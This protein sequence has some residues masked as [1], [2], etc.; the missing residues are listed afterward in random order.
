MVSEA[1]KL[2]S[3]VGKAAILITAE[4]NVLGLSLALC[5]SPFLSLAFLPLLL[6]LLPAP[7][8]ALLF[9]PFK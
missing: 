8:Q 4:P 6:P 9:G 3:F 7:R 2:Q 5:F 1:K